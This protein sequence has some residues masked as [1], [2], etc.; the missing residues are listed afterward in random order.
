MFW[1]F[2]AFQ[3]KFR[4]QKV[5]RDLISSIINFV[6]ELLYELPND[7]GLRILRN[8][9]ILATSQKWLGT[10]PSFLSTPYY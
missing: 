3:F 9:V 10:K 4:L 5:K 6:H 1:P 7:L 2:T 8:Y